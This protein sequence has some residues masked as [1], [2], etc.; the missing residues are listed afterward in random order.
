MD[1][2]HRMEMLP[3]Y[4]NRINQ[5]THGEGRRHHVPDGERVPDHLERRRLHSDSPSFDHLPEC[6][7]HVLHHEVRLPLVHG[8]GEDRDDQRLNV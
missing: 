4:F 7:L 2:V 6:S 1:D 8:P 3:R 5:S